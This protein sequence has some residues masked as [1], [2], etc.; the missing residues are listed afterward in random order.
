MVSWKLVLSK[1]AEL[2]PWEHFWGSGQVQ[3][4]PMLIHSLQ[5]SVANEQ[6]V[7]HC[8]QLEED[9]LCNSTL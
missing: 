9:L 3:M 5:P 6:G 4:T 8:L 7:M 1:T 2:G